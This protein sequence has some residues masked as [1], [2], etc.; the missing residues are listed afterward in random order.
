VTVFIHRVVCTADSH[1][2]GVVIVI[3]ILNIVTIS[4]FTA[5]TAFINTAHPCYAQFDIYHCDKSTVS[6][7]LV[8]QKLK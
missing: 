2:A 3:I 7:F 1:P 6:L 4:L 8:L 5:F